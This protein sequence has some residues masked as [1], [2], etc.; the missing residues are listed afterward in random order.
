MGPS[1]VRLAQALLSAGL[2][3]RIWRLAGLPGILPDP[4][5]ATRAFALAV[6]AILAALGFLSGAA[7][8]AEEERA[9]PRAPYG[10]PMDARPRRLPAHLRR[11]VGFALGAGV[12]HWVLVGFGAEI[13][14]KCAETLCAACVLSSLAVLPWLDGE[15]TQPGGLQRVLGEG[16]PKGNLEVGRCLATGGALLGAWAGGFV[17]PLDWQAPWQAWPL[18]VIYGAVFGH[19]LGAA[20]AAFDATLLAG[21]RKRA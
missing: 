15:R 21:D 3:L 1:G 18:P 4:Y 6:A 12:L 14:S 19:A 5:E 13:W 17:V 2:V 10:L 7:V 20:A 8:A 11:D 16:R 9:T